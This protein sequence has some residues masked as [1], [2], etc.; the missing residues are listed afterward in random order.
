[1]DDL[2]QLTRETT[3]M[4]NRLDPKDWNRVF[5]P[6]TERYFTPEERARLSARDEGEGESGQD[7]W[8][9]L[10]GEAKALTAAGHAPSSPEAMELGCRWM[11]Q[12]KRITGG[13]P[14]VVAKIRTMWDE[15]FTDDEFRE[16]SPVSPELMDYMGEA[17]RAAYTA[18]LI[19]YP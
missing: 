9:D 10:I 3:M 13:D 17:I 19:P 18:R 7:A 11:A 6:L 4:E 15:A 5:A 1:M 12:V 16:R 2:S 8:A 14:A